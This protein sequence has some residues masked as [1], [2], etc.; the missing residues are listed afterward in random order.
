MIIELIADKG[1]ET[2]IKQ[3][4]E[5]RYQGK[6]KNYLNNIVLVSINLTKKLRNIVV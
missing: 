2:G 5:K 1:A 3:I 4:K 6:L